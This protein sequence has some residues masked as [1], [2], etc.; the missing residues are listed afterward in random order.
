MATRMQQAGI[1]GR[2]EEA[3]VGTVREL[4][5]QSLDAAGNQAAQNLLTTTTKMEE[6]LVKMQS[7][8]EEI[9]KNMELMNSEKEILKKLMEQVHS[10]G[11]AAKSTLI[12]QS[13]GM[14]ELNA[15]L[16]KVKTAKD[17]IASDLV[18]RNAEMND[19]VGKLREAS[20]AAFQRVRD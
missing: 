15:D 14:K 11:Q 12:A 19:M 2:H 5:A 17:Q 3:I 8:Q 13:G 7:Q 9:K 18:A 10:E 16:D 4:I 20:S 1:E 6:L